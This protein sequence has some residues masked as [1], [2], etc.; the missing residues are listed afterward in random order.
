[1]FPAGLK[2][3]KMKKATVS[4]REL[5]AHK[6]RLMTAGCEDVIRNLG[7]ADHDR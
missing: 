4:E 1:M 5:I 7:I 6:L 2:S 3:T